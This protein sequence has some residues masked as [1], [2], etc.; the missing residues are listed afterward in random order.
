MLTNLAMPKPI[1]ILNGP[2][3]NVLERR[4]PAR[5]G[6]VSLGSIEALCAER[7]HT[8]GYDITFR[9]TNHEGVLV[10]H[11]HEASEEAD[12]VVINPAAFG[13]TSIALHDALQIV[14]VPII[15]V[16]LSLPAAREPFRARSFVSPLAKGCIAGLGPLSY[17]L[18]VEAACAL[19]G[20]QPSA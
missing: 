16:H 5:Y 8:L 12:A 4:D 2:N 10:E 18:G 20:P 19:A 11:V 7:A 17:V 3:L 6:G 14:T 13:H 9:Q 15:E 1:F